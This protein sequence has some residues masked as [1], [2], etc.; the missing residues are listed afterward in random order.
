M[1]YGGTHIK[2]GHSIFRTILEK[3][4]ALL[5]FF[6]SNIIGN[7]SLSSS[8]SGSKPWDSLVF[9]QKTSKKRFTVLCQTV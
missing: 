9:V 3:D 4:S 7:I 8:I 1:F 2:V 6:I 5:A